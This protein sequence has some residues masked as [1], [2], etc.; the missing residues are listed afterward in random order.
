MA[1]QKGKDLLL[2][3]YVSST[4]TF[5]TVA[6]LRAT[7]INFNAQSV[8][9]TNVAS[10]G[11]WRELLAGAGVR[12]VNIGGNGVFR[13]TETDARM[14]EVFFNSEIPDFQV[15]IPDFGVLEGPFMLTALEYSGDYDGEAQFELSLASS[16]VPS[17][18]A[19]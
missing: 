19:L 14:R 1:A 7:R 6:G 2:K 11:G 12:S 8:N 9:I 4:D 17:F 3:I 10:Q 5:E 18:T 13:D 15:I 16:G